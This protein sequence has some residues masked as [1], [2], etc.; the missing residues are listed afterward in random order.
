MITTH[1]GI[2]IQI[3]INKRKSRGDIPFTHIGPIFAQGYI[4]PSNFSFHSSSGENKHSCRIMSASRQHFCGDTVNIFGHQDQKFQWSRAYFYYSSHSAQNEV[5]WT[6]GIA[7]VG[8][9]PEVFYCKVVVSWWAEKHIP[10][11]RIIPLRDHS[12]ISLSPQV[13]PKM[14]K[15]SKPTMTFRG[16]DCKQFL[17]RH[18]NGLDILAEFLED[19]TT[20]PE[21][22]TKLQVSSY[23]NPF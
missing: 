13:F 21:D 8:Y 6:S 23:R 5:I 11:Q 16:Q 4:I 2:A 9:V 14:L 19:S 7:R 10:R 12:P 20:I 18:D 15:L 22:I 1:H 17:E 3:V